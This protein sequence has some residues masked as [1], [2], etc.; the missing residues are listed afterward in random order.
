MAH[1][2]EYH[3]HIRCKCGA[4]FR[5]H[6]SLSEGTSTFKVRCPGCGGWHRVEA[7]LGTTRSEAR[8]SNMQ[9]NQFQKD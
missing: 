6:D 7:K 4:Q 2:H 8:Q 5:S 3:M 9:C 1:E